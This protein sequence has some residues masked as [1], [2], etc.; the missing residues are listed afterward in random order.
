MALERA[1]RASGLNADV[2]RRIADR[3]SRL[4]PL[5]RNPASSA[6]GL[7]QFTRDTWL[8]AVRDFG[9]RHGL[10]GY[11]AVLV[12][13]RDGNI[14]VRDGRVLRRILRLRENP[15]LSA[16]LAA[17]RL[18]QARPVLETSIGRPARAADLYLVHLLGPTGARRFLA[19]LNESP[20]RSS[21]AVVGE[22]SKRNPGVFERGGRAL[23]L[24]KVYAE[25]AEM[26]G[27]RDTPLAP[28]VRESTEPVLIATSEN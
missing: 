4:N 21:V 8:E 14:S 17:E 5:A 12:T 2:L 13:D 7:M 26:F 16:I 25:V 27:P 11:A 1:E 20:R 18:K 24:G 9:S 19:A 15:A 23:P 10:A 3:E 6:T 28:P 22:A